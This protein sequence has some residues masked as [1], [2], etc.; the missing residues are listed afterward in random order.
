MNLAGLEQIRLGVG[1]TP[2]DFAVA[3]AAAAGQLVDKPLHEIELI[4]VATIYSACAATLED[5]GTRMLAAHKVEMEN[6]TACEL[7][8]EKTKVIGLSSALNSML[9]MVRTR[10][11]NSGERSDHDHA[12]R[13]LQEYGE[14]PF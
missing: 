3:L 8:A 12:G 2:S 9:N 6:A 11:L 10:Q 5:R 7:K 4:E 13:A 1:M 14:L